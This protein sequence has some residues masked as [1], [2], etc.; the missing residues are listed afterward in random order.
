MLIGSGRKQNYLALLLFIAGML[1][2]GVAVYFTQVEGRWG[3]PTALALLL[4]L[5]GCALIA[6][7]KVEEKK[8]GEE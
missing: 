7:E 6:L 1:A 2:G 5:A 3:I 4:M 8:I